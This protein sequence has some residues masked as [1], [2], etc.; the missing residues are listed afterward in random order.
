MFESKVQLLFG[1]H[2]DSSSI[3]CFSASEWED[4]NCCSPT[5]E[6]ESLYN[7][8]PQHVP[9]VCSTSATPF[10]CPSA[11]E[12]SFSCYI[13]PFH[14]LFQTDSVMGLWF[15]WASDTQEVIEQ[16][17]ALCPL[18][19]MSYSGRAGV[20]LFNAELSHLLLLNT[21]AF[22]VLNWLHEVD[23]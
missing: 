19:V 15:C 17:T 16:K 12:S 1:T 13:L 5:Q 11:G 20:C 9:R 2:A 22:V 7:T 6:D 21:N 18:T 14:W 3:Q 10:I 23:D 4:R 8:V